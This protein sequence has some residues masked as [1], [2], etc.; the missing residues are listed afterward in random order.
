MPSALLFD[1]VS[2]IRVSRPW[3]SMTTA[4]RNAVVS[5]VAGS[6]AYLSDNPNLSLFTQSGWYNVLTT[7]L[8]NSGQIFVGNSSNLAAAATVTGDVALSNAGVATIQSGAVTASKIASGTITNTQIAS[9]TITSTQISS[10][11]GI[12]SSQISSSAGI[13]NGQLSATAISLGLAA[14]TGISLN[15]VAGV[16]TVT[17]SSTG[18]VVVF[19]G[20]S[21]A[22]GSSC[23]TAIGSGYTC[24]RNSTGN[25]TVTYPTFG[26]TPAC[27]CNGRVLGGVVICNPASVSSTTFTLQLSDAS[28]T[29]QDDLGWSFHCGH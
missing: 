13:T 9:G 1:V 28:G 2:T 5:P 19:G 25:Y 18:Q 23:G 11:A 20:G 4:Q 12:T 27:V 14:G 10:S 29:A 3:P 16:T 7:N 17:N 21:G 15:T 26:A 22:S 24:V 6:A 8:L